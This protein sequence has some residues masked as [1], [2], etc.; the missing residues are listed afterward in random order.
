MAASSDDK[1][2]LAHPPPALGAGIVGSPREATKPSKALLSSHFEVQSSPEILG[3][4]PTAGK[5]LFLKT[6]VLWAVLWL[7]SEAST[8]PFPPETSR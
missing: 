2:I 6:A 3:V 1:G 8:K 7:Y 5:S 4:I